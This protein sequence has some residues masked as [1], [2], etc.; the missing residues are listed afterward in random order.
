M[1]KIN[2]ECLLAL[3]L[4][5]VIRYYDPMANSAVPR[6]VQ[7]Y[8]HYEPTIREAFHARLVCFHAAKL[9]SLARAISRLDEAFCNREVSNR[10][11]ARN[12]RLNAEVTRILESY[13]LKH[14]RNHD[15]RGYAVKIHFPDGSFNTRG[16]QEDGWGI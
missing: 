5:Q 8:R 3:K 11:Q 12:V 6:I 2:E 7:E 14:M 16:G 4:Y 9:K 15:P 1:P 13:G 10:E